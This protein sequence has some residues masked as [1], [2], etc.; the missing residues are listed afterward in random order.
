MLSI[1]SLMS[2]AVL[3]AEIEE[4]VAAVSK[5][6]GDASVGAVL[7]VEADRLAGIFSE[8]DLL[9]RVIA[10]GRDPAATEVGS[11]ATRDV[12]SV[13]PKVSLRACADTL[14]AHGV[15]HLPVVEEGRIV[16]IISARDFFEAVTGEL[17]S[18]I[19]RHRYEEQIQ[20]NVDPY[21]HMGG[22][23]GR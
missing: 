3:T 10:A 23:Y 18:Y 19:E 22:A 13:D 11:V 7:I 12:V 1:D 15:R 14:K 17:E 20:G 9:T 21:D 16:G 8:R 4:T 6:M 5:R 2:K